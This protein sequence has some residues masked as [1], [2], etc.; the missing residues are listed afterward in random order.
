M[1]YV[2]SSDFARTSILPTTSI[3]CHGEKKSGQPAMSDITIVID[4]R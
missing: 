3:R 4:L 1:L 2:I